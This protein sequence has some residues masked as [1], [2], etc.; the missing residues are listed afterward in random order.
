MINFQ[1]L[2][3]SAFEVHFFHDSNITRLYILQSREAYDNWRSYGSLLCKDLALIVHI[4]ITSPKFNCYLKQILKYYTI[5][6]H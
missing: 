5:I 4:F 6:W 3:S 1:F 2:F